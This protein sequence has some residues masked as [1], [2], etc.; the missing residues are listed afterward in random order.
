LHSQCVSVYVSAC[1]WE[2][3]LLLNCYESNLLKLS[4]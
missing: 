2:N 4:N 3:W 1:L